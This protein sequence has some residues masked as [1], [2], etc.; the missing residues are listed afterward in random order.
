MRTRSKSLFLGLI[1]AATCA[2]CSRTEATKGSRKRETTPPLQTAVAFEPGPTSPVAE[3][4]IAADSAPVS[5]DTAVAIPPALRR[6]KALSC[7]GQP[8]RADELPGVRVTWEPAAQ[9]ADSMTVE[10]YFR[11]QSLLD[12]GAPPEYLLSMHRQGDGRTDQNTDVSIS[13]RDG[14]EE[15]LAYFHVRHRAGDAGEGVYGTPVSRSTLTAGTWHHLAAT[16]E[17]TRTGELA[18]RTFLDGATVSSS[19]SAKPEEPHV[20]PLELTLCC[21]VTAT[22]MFTRPFVGE[23]DDVQVSRGVRYREAFVPTPPAADGDTLLLMRFDDGSARDEGPRRMR[24]E[25]LGSPQF[26]A[27]ER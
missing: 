4:P 14:R 15:R 1:V 5:S 19:V 17:R 8:N 2:S 26:V 12:R 6:G 16:F 9:P 21:G 24:V 18:M 20:A 10:L 23:I 13:L 25:R 3:P 22:G 27:V 7:S 11:A